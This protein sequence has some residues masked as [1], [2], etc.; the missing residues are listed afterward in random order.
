[1]V[2]YHYNNFRANFHEPSKVQVISFV[3][4]VAVFSDAAVFGDTNL[5]LPSFR[6][7]RSVVEIHMSVA[8]EVLSR[9]D[10]Y[11]QI[12]LEVPLHARYAVSYLDSF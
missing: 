12:N 6:S 10:N 3:F 1:M 7:N 11:L 2:V 4:L 8:S 5:E 9:Y